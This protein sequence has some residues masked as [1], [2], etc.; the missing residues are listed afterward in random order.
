VYARAGRRYRSRRLLSRT[1]DGE[2][3]TVSPVVCL[4]PAEAR[5][6]LTNIAFVLYFS[7]VG[8]GIH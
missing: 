8:S 7:Y 3:R 1:T 6:R 2:E 5:Q 4:W